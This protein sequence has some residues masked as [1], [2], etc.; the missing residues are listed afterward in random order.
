MKYQSLEARSDFL[1]YLREP[2][3]DP[4]NTIFNEAIQTISKT[5]VYTISASLPA[6]HPIL[7]LTRGAAESI[8]R[9]R[10]RSSRREP[11]IRKIPKKR[12]QWR[13]Y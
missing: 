12:L 5:T 4:P 10:P 11:A 7:L 3:G 6:T 9:R 8:W 13:P 1:V 2:P